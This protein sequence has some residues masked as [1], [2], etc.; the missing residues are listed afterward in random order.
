MPATACRAVA[1]SSAAAAATRQRQAAAGA[2]AAKQQSKAAAAPAVEEEKPKATGIRGLFG[3]AIDFMDQTW[4]QT[5]MYIIFLLT[6][7]SLTQ[8]MRRPQEFYMDKYI[9]DT[10]IINT[11]D[12][13]HN[14]FPA[15]RRIA[16][17]W[18]WCN[19]VLIA[20]LFSNAD[21]GEWW[22]DGDGSFHLED[23][24]PYS[25]QDMVNEMNVFDFRRGVIFRQVR[26]ETT[27]DC[28][29]GHKCFSDVGNDGIMIQSGSGNTTSFG[30]GAAAGKFRYWSTESLGANPAGTMS[31][32]PL[33]L[34]TWT[35]SGFIAIYMPFFSETYLPDETGAYYDVTDYRLTEATLGNDRAPNYYCARYT[36][37]GH[38]ITQRCN[39]TPGANSGVTRAMMVELVDYLKKGHWIDRQTRMVLIT[40]QLRS[41]NFGLRFLSRFMFEITNMGAVL[42]SFDME[43]MLDDEGLE[44]EQT[45]WMF[46]AL[47]LV[48]WFIMLE[49]IEIWGSG[50]AEYFGNLWNV[51]DWANFLLFFMVY[52]L[53]TQQ[54]EQNAR[55][56]L[57]LEYD[58]S[59]GSHDCG[60]VICNQFG[61]MDMWEVMN[62]ARDAKFYMSMCVCLQ[63]LKII[64]FTNVIV[65]KMSLMTS[66]LSK[67]CYDL[68]FFGIIFGLSMFSFCMLFYIQL[69]SF[70][71]DYH[72]QTSSIVALALA[73]FGDFPFAEILDNSRGY[74]NGILFLVYLFIAVFILLSMFL[75]ILGE[76]Q[77]AA[78]EDE[79][80]AKA[81]GSA[82][83]PYGFFGEG[84]DWVVKKLGELKEMRS[85]GAD[86][87]G[88]GEEGLDP[89]DGPDAALHTA[90]TKL[91]ARLEGT[92]KQRLT[93][94][95][96]RLLRELTKM[97]NEHREATARLEASAAQQAR[98]RSAVKKS[99]TTSLTK[100]EP[101][102]KGS[103]EGKEAK[104]G[105]DGREGR[106]GKGG[107]ADE[108]DRLKKAEIPSHKVD[109]A[110]PERSADGLR[111]GSSKR[112]VKGNASGSPETVDT[113]DG[114]GGDQGS[115]SRTAPRDRASPVP[116]TSHR[117]NSPP[118]EWKKV[119]SASTGTSAVRARKPSIEEQIA[120]SPYGSPRLD[121]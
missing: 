120:I 16:D 53:L 32:N 12:S 31:A 71:D 97:G 34:R 1:A 27:R 3:K 11:F 50:P 24:T 42:P 80:M 37:N 90:L 30:H 20:G 86:K 33:S 111:T 89:L 25:T 41:N 15:I 98:S 63:L 81:D 75:A 58:S 68:L 100:Q 107:S 7:Q 18:E 92:M 28:F 91:Q 59:S 94:I 61:F 106:D 119:R 5:V 52:S 49:A 66:V 64:K 70:M 29:H 74:T 57:R 46:V 19:T 115:R 121:A 93:A 112:R 102:G 39:P 47:V 9:Q 116:T 10:F 17:I 77:A 85:G 73:L 114:G 43:A 4:L 76:A 55:D 48:A 83:N 69:G 65:P 117:T 109:R 2:E 54:K 8:T 101:S 108:A 118:D 62:T 14:D 40:M 60:S 22:P 82:P 6:F 44:Q 105:R 23:A 78:R 79:M 99:S 88:E 45:T 36:T 26:A 13:N 72:S 67:G 51:M 84:K 96:T 38:D 87:E 21:A 35:S 104:E 110:S 113:A 56:N 95:E 103:R